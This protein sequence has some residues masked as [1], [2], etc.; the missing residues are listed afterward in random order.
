MKPLNRIV[1]LDTSDSLKEFSHSWEALL[2]NEI[3]I[4]PF[5]CDMISGRTH[6]F[7]LHFKKYLRD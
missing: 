1:R 3:T 2:S 6:D 5:D 4:P 7:L